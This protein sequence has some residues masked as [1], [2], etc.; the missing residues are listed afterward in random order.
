MTRPNFLILGAQKAATTSL[1]N[2]L[3]Q[4]PDV[5]VSPVKEPHYFALGDMELP[6]QMPVQRL[7]GDMAS[8]EALFD[9][10]QR[11]TAIGEAST[12]YLDSHRAAR[13][14]HERLPDA[15][16]IAV[17]RDPAERAHSHYVFNRKRLLDEAATL[18]QG[19]ALEAERLASGM[20][21]R[22]K[23]L[24]KGFYHEQ[25]TWYFGLFNREQ[26]RVFLYEDFTNDPFGMIREVFEFLEVDP[27]FTPNMNVRYNVSGVPRN[28]IAETLLRRLG[29][30]RLFLE[31][32]LPPQLVSRMG[33]MFIRSKAQDS[34]LRRKLVDAYA[35]DIRQLQGL[36]GRDLS[37]WLR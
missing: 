6:P 20:G 15:K 32:S 9:G 2:Y 30:L 7:M 26:I 31:R 17:L 29:P 18:E 1:H 23:Y 35:D 4:H 28:K 36:I 5:F 13:R 19:L 34:E 16:L 24:G 14:I 10:V 37:G 12:T 25:L 8:Y 21:P 27:D 11:E 22:F 33:P 3:G